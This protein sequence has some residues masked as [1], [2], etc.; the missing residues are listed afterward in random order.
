[1]DILYYVNGFTLCAYVLCGLKGRDWNRKRRDDFS[2]LC[3][4]H[5]VI[6][7]ASIHYGS[8]M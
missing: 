8:W 6:T 3:Y 5:C 2:S 1:M 7:R 4:H